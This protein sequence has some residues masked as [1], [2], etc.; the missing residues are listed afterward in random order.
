MMVYWTGVR[1]I[2]AEWKETGQIKVWSD[3]DIKITRGDSEGTNEYIDEEQV[4]IYIGRDEH[5]NYDNRQ[6]CRIFHFYEQNDL[7]TVQYILPYGI[8]HIITWKPSRWKCEY[9]P[10]DL[11]LLYD[12]GSYEENTNSDEVSSV[13]LQSSNT[14]TDDVN[15][16]DNSST[17]ET[18][19]A[20]LTVSRDRQIHKRAQREKH[21]AKPY[22]NDV[23][24]RTAAGLIN[25]M[26][27]ADLDHDKR[28]KC[29]V[30]ASK[31]MKSTVEAEIIE[32]EH[33][34]GRGIIQTANDKAF[35]KER[36]ITHIGPIHRGDIV[37]ATVAERPD[38]Q[39]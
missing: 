26:I 30:E 14:S 27:T 8:T 15:E 28:E 38:G 2:M 1:G 13:K 36:D 29:M 31:N 25:P 35:L 23:R 7:K 5:D 20:A 4:K 3:I 11:G 19:M 33:H 39:G 34:A 24:L 6:Y 32:W 17:V 21:S 22:G 37:I 12:R 16:S 18:A 10:D 9:V